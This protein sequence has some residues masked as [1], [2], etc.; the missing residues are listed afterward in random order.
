[1]D[2]QFLLLLIGLLFGAS[3]LLVIFSLARLKTEVP[4]DDREYMDKLPPV[5]RLLWPLVRFLEYHVTA[6]MPSAALEK[7]RRN[8]CPRKNSSFFSSAP[9]RN[10][11]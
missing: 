7:S 11:I 9:V 1:M 5:L 2:D 6:F 3:V 8:S 10:V 4:D